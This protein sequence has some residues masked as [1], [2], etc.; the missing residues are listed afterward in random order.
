MLS[1]AMIDNSQ[2]CTTVRQ[3]TTHEA[4]EGYPYPA[5]PKVVGA[6]SAV[7]PRHLA[8]AAQ[9]PARA[10]DVLSRLEHPR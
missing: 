1:T 9:I 10:A 2:V 5:V 4:G 3:G 6:A 8:L 7:D